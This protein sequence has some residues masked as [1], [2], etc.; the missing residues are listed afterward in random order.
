[1]AADGIGLKSVLR[2]NIPTLAVLLKVRRL[3]AD[4][5]SYVQPAPFEAIMFSW[6]E[7]G[8]DAQYGA[9][10]VEPE[11]NASGVEKV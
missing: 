3:V 10:V 5:T 2:V 7:L 6:E 8:E 11:V 9:P 1:M 4:G